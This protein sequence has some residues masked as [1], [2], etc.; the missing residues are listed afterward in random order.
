MTSKI[1]KMMLAWDL[2][3]FERDIP[4]LGIREV[5]RLIK[6]R[7]GSNPLYL[8]I[9]I[10]VLDPAFAPASGTPEAGGLSSRELL[11]ILRGINTLNIISTDIV[12]VALIYDHAE[13]TSIAANHLVYEIISGW[14]KG[15]VKA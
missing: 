4:D 8:S 15:R 9:D 7:V 11:A 12:E 2:A 1:W 13:I 3:L 6:E 5:V 14:S 10:D